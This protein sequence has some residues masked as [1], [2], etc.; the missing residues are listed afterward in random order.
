MSQKLT[1][2]QYSHT[3]YENFKSIN[4]FCDIFILL[5]TKFNISLLLLTFSPQFI[6]WCDLDKHIGQ[7][8]CKI[9]RIASDG[10][11]LLN[12]IEHC[13][14]IDHNIKLSD[15]SLSCKLFQEIKKRSGFYLQFTQ[16]TTEQALL[17]DMAK[18]LNRKKRCYTI[19]N[20]D[21]ILGAACNFLNININII[22]QFQGSV[23]EIK[24]IPEG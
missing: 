8:G 5:K 6:P 20:V 12:A 1:Y 22:E 3:V 13:L 7:L 18:Y 4:P 23:K 2:V 11:C 24:F 17:Q 21:L 19:P 9:D 14:V 10:Q 16:N 15:K